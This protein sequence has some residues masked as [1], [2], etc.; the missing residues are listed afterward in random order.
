[1]S[2]E[3]MEDTQ[4]CGTCLRRKP[5]SEFAEGRKDCLACEPDGPSVISRLKNP[6]HEQCRTCRKHF[7]SNDLYEGQCVDCE[8]S[9]TPKE[10]KKLVAELK[11]SQPDPNKL[12]YSKAKENTLMMKYGITW[13]SYVWMHKKQRWV[14]AICGELESVN[15]KVFSIRKK[16]LSVDHNH[17]T[18][19][20]RG[21]LCNECNTGLG[22]FKDKVSLLR[23]AISYLCDPPCRDVRRIRK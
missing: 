16:S 8:I 15:A 6:G 10:I 4:V 13:R 18:N 2:E 1:M 14:C 20:I 7:R 9:T 12:R 21:L 23:R 19:A 5:E 3:V 11:R 17:E 22:K